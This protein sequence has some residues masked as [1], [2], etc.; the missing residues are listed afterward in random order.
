MNFRGIVQHLNLKMT[1]NFDDTVVADDL[2]GDDTLTVNVANERL[3]NIEA[4]E[5][6]V[7]EL[8]LSQRFEGET[9]LTVRAG[10]EV[11][12]R[13]EWCRKIFIGW[14][15]SSAQSARGKSCHGTLLSACADRAASRG[16][17]RGTTTGSQ[18]E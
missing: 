3:A 9:L 17:S 11:P 5:S 12:P 6:I 13:G 16:N 15:L 8:D 7:T 2:D 10:S 1:I 18:Y 4:A 14:W